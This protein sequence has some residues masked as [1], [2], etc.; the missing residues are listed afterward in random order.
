MTTPDEITRR[1]DALERRLNAD[2]PAGTTAGGAMLCVVVHGCLPPGVPLFAMAGEHEWLRG[3]D[4]ELVA[5]ADR[6][7]AGAREAGEQRLV[8]GGLPR[9]QAQHEVAQAAHAAWLLTDDGVPPLEESRG[10]P[11]PVERAIAD[12]DRLP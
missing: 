10:L 12:R 2:R 5:F 11:S 7:K 6:A 4:E 3:P 8:L 9:S 1:L